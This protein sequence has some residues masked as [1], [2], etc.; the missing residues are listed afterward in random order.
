MAIP[1]FRFAIATTLLAIWSLPTASTWAEETVPEVTVRCIWDAGRHNAFTDLIRHD[2]KFYCAF[3]EADHHVPRDRSGDGKARVLVSEDGQTW[4]SAGLIELDG[5]DLRDP[6]LSVTPEG[7]IMVVM[8]GSHY[9]RGKLLKRVPTAALLNPQTGKIEPPVSLKID[10]EIAGNEDWLWRVTWHKGVGYGVVYQPARSSWGTHLVKTTDGLQYDLVHTL[11]LPGKPNESTVRFTPEGE[12]RIVVRNEDGKPRGHL[13]I[14]NPPYT[15]FTWQ[16]IN[17][18]LGGPNIVQLPGGDWVLGS[19][20]YGK[21]TQTVLGILSDDGKF[22]RR[23]TLPSGG[24]T[25]YPGLL[26]HEGEL[27]VSYYSSHEGK[28]AIYLAT[29][30]LERFT[31]GR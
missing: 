1:H 6:K 15:E 21:P 26:V 13:G 29:V 11:K 16:E 24:D 8:G 28:S 23:I 7:K 22:D 25:S 18:K 14:A 17:H 30:P 27:W 12:M 4:A 31:Q 2:G 3:R 9:E 20:A 10:S 5:V 19:R